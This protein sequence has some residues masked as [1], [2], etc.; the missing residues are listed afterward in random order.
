[1]NILDRFLSYVAIDTASDEDSRSSPTTQ[2]QFQLAEVLKAELLSLGLKN[3]RVDEHCYVYGELP[4]THG[5]EQSKAIGL[6]AHMDTVKDFG[7]IVKPQIISHYDATDVVLGSSGRTLQVS[8][9]PHLAKLKGKTLITT[10]GT[11]VLGADDK[12]GIAE[13][14]AV[15]EELQK[16]RTPHGRISVCFTPDEETGHGAD[17]FDVEAFNADY[18]FTLDGGDAGEITYENFNACSASWEI[19]GLNVHTGDAKNKMI[20]A[21]LVAMEINSMLPSG[22]I[23]SRTAGY[24]GFY[25]LCDMSGSVPLKE[26]NSEMELVPAYFH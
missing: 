4:A 5:L 17:Y 19:R 25:H 21:A 24:E 14:M 20:N 3:V 7:G 26:I 9:F 18:A 13:I 8:K 1:M 10:D 6:I 15:L 2:T 11:T 12:A 16:T 22:D 23:P